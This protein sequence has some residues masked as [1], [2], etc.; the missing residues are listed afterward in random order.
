MSKL[1]PEQILKFDAFMEDWR[2]NHC[3]CE[4]TPIYIAGAYFINKATT[5]YDE[6]KA[7][8]NFNDLRR[9]KNGKS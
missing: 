9:T 1:T 2:R 4:D 7:C 6:C 3:T 5:S 8:Q